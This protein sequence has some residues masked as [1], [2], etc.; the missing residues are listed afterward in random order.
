M[1]SFKGKTGEKGCIF[2]ML[3]LFYLHSMVTIETF[4]HFS[5]D[6]L[7]GWAFY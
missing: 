1:G 6:G 2:T 5:V 4:S 3:W 7:Y